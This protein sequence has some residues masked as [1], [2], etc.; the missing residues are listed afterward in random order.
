MNAG[1][2]QRGAWLWQP[3]PSDGE[4]LPEVPNFR[5]GFC[6]QLGHGA[7]GEFF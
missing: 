3:A 7:E 2:R 6:F 4:P 1:V 5:E